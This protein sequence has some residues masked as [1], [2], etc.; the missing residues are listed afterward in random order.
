MRM[1]ILRPQVAKAPL[2]LLPRE[3]WWARSPVFNMKAALGLQLVWRRYTAFISH[4]KIQLDW[5]PNTRREKW[6]P[7]EPEGLRQF[8]DRYWKALS[9]ENPNLL[10]L[11]F[12]SVFDLSF[13]ETEVSELSEILWF[14]RGLIFKVVKEVKLICVHSI[15]LCSRVPAI[16]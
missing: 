11:F 15:I 16:I 14:V 12:W 9:R 2:C 3:V 10:S 4:Y 5:T 1:D 6:F 13:F 7:N 8:R